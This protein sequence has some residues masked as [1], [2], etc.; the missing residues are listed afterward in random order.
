MI[1]QF[2]VIPFVLALLYRNCSLTFKLN[3]ILPFSRGCHY[4]RCSIERGVLEGFVGFVEVGRGVPVLQSLFNKV[5]NLRGEGRAWG[6]TSAWEFFLCDL[7][8]F[9][10]HLFWWASDNDSFWFFKF[11]HITRFLYT[12]SFI[13]CIYLNCV[14]NQIFCCLI[15]EI[16]FY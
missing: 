16:Y 6:E 11:W 9:W 8:N 1:Y 2:R 14:T 7:Q 15:S 13:I 12:V 3:H 5:A 10:E 4:W